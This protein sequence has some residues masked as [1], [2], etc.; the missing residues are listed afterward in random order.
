[1]KPDSFKVKQK[2]STFIPVA[3]LFKQGQLLTNLHAAVYSAIGWSQC[4][5]QLSLTLGPLTCI[6]EGNLNH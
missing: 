3:F 6:P 2:T 5:A 4:G 1:M